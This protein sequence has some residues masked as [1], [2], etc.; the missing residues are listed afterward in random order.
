MTSTEHVVL[1]DEQ[2][3]EL[4]TMEKMQA[5]REGRLHRA[6]SIFVF[7]DQNEMLLQR[8]A[9]SKY[10]SPGLWSNACCSHPRPGEAVVDAAHRRLQEELGFDCALNPTFSFL[11]RAQLEAGL[12]EH[13]YDHVLFGRYS[14]APAPDPAEADACTFEPE[15]VIRQAL[16][17]DPQKFTAWFRL[18]VDRVLAARSTQQVPEN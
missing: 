17:D 14:G 8:R 12:I 2:D 18:C 4:G 7:N 5:H 1:V 15:E 9:A 10:H 3:N 6:F 11:Y 16:A 13:E